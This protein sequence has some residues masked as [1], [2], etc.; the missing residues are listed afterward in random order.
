[1]STLVAMILESITT[2]REHSKGGGDSPVS[3]SGEKWIWWCSREWQRDKGR[4]WESVGVNKAFENSL[5][6]CWVL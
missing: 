4:E 5:Q 2:Q 1:M 6:V 3:W